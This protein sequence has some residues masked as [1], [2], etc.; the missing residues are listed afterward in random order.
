MDFCSSHILDIRQ[1]QTPFLL[2]FDSIKRIHKKVGECK[3]EDLFLYIINWFLFSI[4]NALTALVIKYYCWLVTL[5]SKSYF[6]GFCNICI[7]IYY[8]DAALQVLQTFGFKSSVK[9]GTNFFLLQLSLTWFSLKDPKAHKESFDPVNVVIGLEKFYW[10]N[11]TAFLNFPA[12]LCFQ[13]KFPNFFFF[14][15]K[16]SK[17]RIGTVPL[18]LLL[19]YFI[20]EP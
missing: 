10:T 19:K 18:L 13:L 17:M 11:S 7:Y 20:P 12:Q 14:F 1:S 2:C 16:E 15:F 3:F 6:V 4:G 9:K 8:R 5:S